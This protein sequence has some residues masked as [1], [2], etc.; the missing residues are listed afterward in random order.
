[1]GGVDVCLGPERD[2]CNTRSV[3]RGPDFKKATHFQSV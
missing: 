3:N 2:M 1:M